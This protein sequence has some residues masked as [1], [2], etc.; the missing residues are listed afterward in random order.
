MGYSDDFTYFSLDR[1]W[2]GFGYF[3]KDEVFYAF[4]CFGL[5]AGFFGSL[6]YVISLLFFSPVIVSA[7]FLFEP[8]L[9]Q[10]I[11]FWMKIDHFPGW[12]TWIGTFCVLFGVLSI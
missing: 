3:H 11:G 5:T 4:I 9:G 12:F 6:G 10:M 2:G 1:E 8:F 7:S